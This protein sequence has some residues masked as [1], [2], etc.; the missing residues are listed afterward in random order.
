MVGAQQVQK[1]AASNAD[2]YAFPDRLSSVWSPATQS[3]HAVRP[4]SP[5]TQSG[6][7]DPHGMLSLRT[8][9]LMPAP[10]M[11]RACFV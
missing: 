6:H 11:V 10:G 3:G 5:A 9:T 8:A 1:L 7:G 2:T 4:R